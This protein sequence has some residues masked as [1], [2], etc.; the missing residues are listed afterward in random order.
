MFG[1]QLILEKASQGGS[2]S[3]FS[4]QTASNEVPAMA[5]QLTIGNCRCFLARCFDAG[6]WHPRQSGDGLHDDLGHPP[7]AGTVRSAWAPIK[8]ATNSRVLDAWGLWNRLLT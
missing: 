1:W 4:T 6:A 2:I 8:L 7:T 5:N 3:R